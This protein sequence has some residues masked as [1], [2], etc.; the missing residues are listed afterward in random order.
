MKILYLDLET[1]GVN[2]RECAIVQIGLIAEI[3]GKVV[4]TLD[5]LVKPFDNCKIESGAL[6]VHN[7]TPKAT[8]TGATYSEAYT[9]ITKLLDRYVDKFN[10]RDKFFLVGYNV[11]FDEAFLREMWRKAGD[12]YFGSYFFWPSLD[13]AILAAQYLCDDRH[14]MVNF[15]L[16][17]LADFMGIKLD[18]EAHD[19]VY[20]IRLTRA[21][22]KQVTGGNL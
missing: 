20:D 13:V 1:T 12:V 22:Y 5:F 9:R 2:A 15:K 3:N 4:E 18:G 7:L 11:Q 8:L 19:A 17:S 10:K 16:Q 21:I 14:K 6:N